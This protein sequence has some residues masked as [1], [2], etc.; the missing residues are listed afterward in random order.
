MPSF[1]Q[2]GHFSEASRQKTVT[3]SGFIAGLEWREEIDLPPFVHLV[4]T[5]RKKACK[6]SPPQRSPPPGPRGS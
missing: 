6:F 5:N 3:T 2:D 4:T 1:K